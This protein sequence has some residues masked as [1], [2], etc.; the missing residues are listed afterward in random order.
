M[1]QEEKRKQFREYCKIVATYLNYF[2]GKRDDF[3]YCRR[4]FK[5]ALKAVLWAANRQ[6]RYRDYMYYKRMEAEAREAQAEKDKDLDNRDLL[7][8]FK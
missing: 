1:T 3:P 6:Q 5:K 8:P 2:T 7:P 4:D